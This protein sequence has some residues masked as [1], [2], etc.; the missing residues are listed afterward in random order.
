M[1]TLDARTLTRAGGSPDTEDMLRL[2]GFWAMM[3]DQ[4]RQSLG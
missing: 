4:L 2:R 1:A 3:G